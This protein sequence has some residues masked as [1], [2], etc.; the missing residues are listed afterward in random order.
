MIKK[1]ICLMLSVIMVIVSSVCA[2]ANEQ[3]ENLPST[4]QV[5]NITRDEYLKLY[6]EKYNISI[7]EADQRDRA[8]TELSLQE[9]NQKHST[10]ATNATNDSTAVTLNETD[11]LSIKK[12]FYIADSVSFNSIVRVVVHVK[13]NKYHLEGYG[14]YQKF[15]EI[16]NSGT[17]G[18]GSG[19][20]TVETDIFSAEI[21]KDHGYENEIKVLVDGKINHAIDLSLAVAAEK[22]GFSLTGTVGTTYQYSK[23]IHF[24]YTFFSNANLNG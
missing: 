14:D 8:N 12:D 20:A 9:E 17:V 24:D 16:I 15:S 19:T 11:Y 3:V 2:F 10:M 6:S 18:L 22:A 1:L 4:T 21:G 5:E 13:V 7:E 23:G